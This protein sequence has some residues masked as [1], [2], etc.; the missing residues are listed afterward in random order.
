[1]LDSESQQRSHKTDDNSQVSFFITPVGERA[2]KYERSCL[3]DQEEQLVM[4]W[5]YICCCFKLNPRD[6]V[7]YHATDSLVD[8]NNDD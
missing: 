5:G 1:M 7:I 3:N 2:F 8:E 4:M 6:M